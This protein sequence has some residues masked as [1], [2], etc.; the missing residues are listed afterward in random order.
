LPYRDVTNVCNNS[1][2]CV[3][4]KPIIPRQIIFSADAD[5]TLFTLTGPEW[6]QQKEGKTANWQTLRETIGSNKIKHLAITDESTSP[7]TV[8]GVIELH[9]DTNFSLQTPL[10]MSFHLV[11]KNPPESCQN[12]LY[13]EDKPVCIQ[14]NSILESWASAEA[15][16]NDN[17]NEYEVV[18]S[19]HNNDVK[20][21]SQKTAE[22]VE[23]RLALIA[24]KTD[25]LDKTTRKIISIAVI[26][27]KL[28]NKFKIEG[29][30]TPEETNRLAKEINDGINKRIKI[31]FTDIKFKNAD[32]AAG[33]ENYINSKIEK[34][35]TTAFKQLLHPLACWIISR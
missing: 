26:R 7:A 29:G 27:E 1:Q 30:L 31:I 15:T 14:D 5:E 17:S 13:Y 22:N 16:F 11:E 8:I 4:S 34:P 6:D 2:L 25:A 19:I 12:T 3:E 9:Q 32:A 28:S 18:L 24:T 10:K 33:L 35:K 20:K 23:E 21:F